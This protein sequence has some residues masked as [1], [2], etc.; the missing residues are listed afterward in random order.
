MPRLVFHE[1]V[2]FTVT[3]HQ[4]KG[5]CRAGHEVGDCWEFDW[6]TPGGIC[7]SA[8]HALYPVLHGLML[9]SGRYEGPAARA[10]FPE[11]ARSLKPEERRGASEGAEPHSDPLQRRPAGGGKNRDR[12]TPRRRCPDRKAGKRLMGIEGPPGTDDAQK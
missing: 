3:V 11:N 10:R 9:T 8:Y 5:E 12:V 6:R 2:G 4:A 1:P 7:G